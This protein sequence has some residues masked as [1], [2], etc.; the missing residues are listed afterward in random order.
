MK[1]LKHIIPLTAVCMATLLAAC[2]ADDGPVNGGAAAVIPAAPL[3]ITLRAS[4]PATTRSTEA[5]TTHITTQGNNQVLASGVDVDLFLEEDGTGTTYT[6]QLQYLKATAP[7]GTGDQGVS[8]FSFYSEQERTSVVT[9]YWPPSGSG[10]Y[11]L[12]YYPAG[13]ITGPVTHTTATAQTFTTAADQGAADAAPANDLLFGTPNG[14]PI[15]TPTANPVPRPSAT[16]MDGR[17]VNLN[18][19][20]CLSKVE[21]IIQGDGYGIG[22]GTAGG[23]TEGTDAHKN[24]YD[25]FGRDQFT[26]GTI[27]LGT[28]DDMYLQASIVPSTGAATALETGTKG[29]YSLKNS[30]VASTDHHYYCIM[31][32]QQ[33]TGRTINLTLADGGTKSFAIPQADTDSDGTPDTDVTAQPGK[34]YT[35]TITVGLYSLTVTATVGDWTPETVAGTTL[36]Y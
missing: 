8:N 3:P 28:A 36:K 35:Y 2:T 11:F 5:G 6:G 23:P 4:L 22:N 16:T 21:V 31:P 32:P 19:Q 30:G 12:A 13:S 17:A 18:F 34:V 24:G 33:L 7:S 27:T 25:Q 26:A 15:G 1:Q 29:V 14:A 10:L 9:R 20:H